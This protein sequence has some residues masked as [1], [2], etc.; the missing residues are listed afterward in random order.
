MNV[1]HDNDCMHNIGNNSGDFFVAMN[2]RIFKGKVADICRVIEEPGL[3]PEIDRCKQADIAYSLVVIVE[4]RNGV[5]LSVE[6]PVELLDGCPLNK[7][8]GVFVERF[9]VC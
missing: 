4:P 6:C 7:A 9:R 3:F 1:I 8:D 2:V 5:P